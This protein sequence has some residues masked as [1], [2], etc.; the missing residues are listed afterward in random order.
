M[1]KINI[2][3]DV[4]GNHVEDTTKSSSIRLPSNASNEE[5]RKS[6][7]FP[8]QIRNENKFPNSKCY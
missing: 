3:I 8:K 2:D 7:T 6:K 4:N 5:K 1:K